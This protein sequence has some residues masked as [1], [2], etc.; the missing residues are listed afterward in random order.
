[1]AMSV[2][3]VTLLLCHSIIGTQTIGRTTVEVTSLSHPAAVGGILAISCEIRN[4]Q[5]EYTVSFYRE[6]KD[7]TEQ[8]SG[9]EL[10]YPSALSQRVFISKGTSS[11]GNTIYLLTLVD[12]SYDDNGQYLCSISAMKNRQLVAITTNSITIE[13]F[14]FPSTAYPICKS[15]P[16]KIRVNDGVNL[17]LTCTAE[18]SNPVV[19]LHWR[20]NN[21]HDVF[22]DLDETDNLD[23]VSSEITVLANPLYNGATFECT[24]TSSGF[25]NRQRSC[26]IGPI[27][28]IKRTNERENVLVPGDNAQI[29][30]YDSGCGIPCPPEDT[31]TIMYLAVGTM[32][33]TILMFTFLITTIILCCKYCKISSEVR[34]VQ[35]SVPY[36]DGSEPVYVS[37]QRRPEPDRSSMFMS[38]EDPNNPGNKVLMPRELVEEF[39]RSLSLKRK[40]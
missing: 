9:G 39:Y 4:M 15:I 30:V 34:S 22:T 19:E 28:V 25:S 8:I 29:D 35:R 18:K 33:A 20:T 11:T 23:T 13:I 32:G 31:D 7:I 10:Y 37:L 16:N 1:M 40:K 21:G 38:V 27:T 26:N 17:R 14:S 6:F 12:V 24:M 5:E 3:L 2:A 36:D